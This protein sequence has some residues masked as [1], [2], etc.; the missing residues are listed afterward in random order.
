MIEF[1]SSLK[2]SATH[3]RRFAK[4]TPKTEHEIAKKAF[5]K[6]HERLKAERLAREATGTQVTSPKAKPKKAKSSK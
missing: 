2:L 1:E 3:V 6:N 5:S 4:S